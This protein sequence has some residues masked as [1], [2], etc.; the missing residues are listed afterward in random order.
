MSNFGDS[1]L[2]QSLG[3]AAMALGFGV[4]VGAITWGFNDSVNNVTHIET[5]E[6]SIVIPNGI[7]NQCAAGENNT[8]TVQIT[9]DNNGDLTIACSLRA[10]P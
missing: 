1:E 10:V 5:P 9:R 7:F 8:G 2:G 4:G 3:I 6:D